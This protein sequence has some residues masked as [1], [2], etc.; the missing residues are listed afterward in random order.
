MG[1]QQQPQQRRW[2]QQEQQPLYAYGQAVP[3]P[4]LAP[5][6]QVHS[7]STIDHLSTKSPAYY[8]RP[9]EDVANDGDNGANAIVHDDTA[10]E[11]GASLLAEL[12][13]QS[14]RVG[15]TLAGPSETTLAIGIRADVIT[16]RNIFTIN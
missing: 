12:A 7:K 1:E 5:S 11:Q 8:D 16:L 13:S 2:W 10:L 15:R 3:E 9:D 6:V 4:L 14:N